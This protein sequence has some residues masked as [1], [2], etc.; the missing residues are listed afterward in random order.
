MVPKLFLLEYRL[1]VPCC[2]RVS[3]QLGPWNPILPNISRSWVW[4]TRLDTN[5]A[6]MKWLLFKL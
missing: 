2:H 5:A 6:W 1:W 4:Q 3:Y